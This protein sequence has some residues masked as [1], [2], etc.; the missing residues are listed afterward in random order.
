M[1]STTNENNRLNKESYN[2][3]PASIKNNGS[4]PN[5]R[6]SSSS[7]LLDLSAMPIQDAYNLAREFVKAKEGTRAIQMSYDERNMMNV[8]TKQV[9]YGKLQ[10]EKANVGFLDLV[11]KD[12]L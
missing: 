12:R 6:R 5:E 8:L 11:G 9:H 2:L 7:E 4:I 3:S 10:E 1:A